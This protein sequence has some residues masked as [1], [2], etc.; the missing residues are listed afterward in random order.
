VVFNYDRCIEHFLYHAIQTVYR[1]KAEDAA[2]TLRHLR[3][4]HPYGTVGS[5]PWQTDS[6]G[7]TIEF[8]GEVDAHQLNALRQGIRTY[9]EKLGEYKGLA[10]I[11]EAVLAANVVVFLG[12]AFHPDNMALLTPEDQR[13]AADTTAFYAT[14][15]NESKN[16]IAVVE[17][18]IKALRKVRPRDHEYHIEDLT[19]V[20]LFEHYSKTFEFQ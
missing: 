18:R 17:G 13:N 4:F 7:P 16:N 20:K 14:L 12:F 2:A 3:I 9:S 1:V 5:L 11:R 10:P 8:G 6:A 15:L 19:C